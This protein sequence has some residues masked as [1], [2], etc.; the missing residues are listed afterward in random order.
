VQVIRDVAAILASAPAA[1][2]HQDHIE[3][4]LRLARA[5]AEGL[6]EAAEMTARLIAVMGEAADAMSAQ[7]AKP[8]RR[9]KAGVE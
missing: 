2:A 3:I 6:M 8:K 1:G 5:F 7:Q 9:R 4:D